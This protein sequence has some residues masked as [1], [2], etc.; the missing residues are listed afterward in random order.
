M[1]ADDTKLWRQIQSSADCYILQNDIDYMQNWAFQ[2]K[3]T[4]NPK[5]C[6]AMQISLKRANPL[7]DC[8]PFSLYYYMLGNCIIDFSSSEKDLGVD[9]TDTL[10][11]SNQCNRLY[12]KANQIFGLTKRTAHFINNSGQRRALYLAIIRSQFEHRSVVWRPYSSTSISKLES[13][14]KRCIKWILS[15]EFIHYSQNTYFQKC[16]SLDILPLQFRFALNDLTFFHKIFYDLC[17]VKFP[18]YLKPFSGSSLRTSHLDCL[19][20]VSEIIPRT[21][22]SAISSFKP[23]SNTFFYRT[24]SAWNSLPFEIRNISCP[25]KFKQRVTEVIWIR[26]REHFLSDLSDSTDYYNNSIHDDGG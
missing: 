3:M 22:S 1:Y 26:A 18:Y 23:F 2:N 7:L 20:I 25:F 14:Q 4:F 6:K 10:N 12:N 9:I 17:P 24:H 13:L 8:L 19:S 11:W 21:N 16:K 15:E 5:K